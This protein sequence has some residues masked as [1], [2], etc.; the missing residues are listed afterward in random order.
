[1]I[2]AGDDGYIR[3]WDAHEIET[4]EGD[5]NLNYYMKPSKEF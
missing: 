3:F 5:D 1:L 4:A 2:T